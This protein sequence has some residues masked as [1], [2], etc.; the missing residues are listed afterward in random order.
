MV[1]NAKEVSVDAAVVALF[2]EK[3]FFSPLIEESSEHRRSQVSVNNIVLEE[4]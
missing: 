1:A 4:S 3:L 2:V